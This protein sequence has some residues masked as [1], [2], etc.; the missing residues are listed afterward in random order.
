M[1]VSFYQ[2]NKIQKVLFPGLPR[3]YLHMVIHG[4]VLKK[5]TKPVDEHD[6][7]VSNRLGKPAFHSS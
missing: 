5:Y 3:R 2:Y 6:L 4:F 7:Q 1:I